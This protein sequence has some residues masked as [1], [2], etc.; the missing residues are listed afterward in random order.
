MKIISLIS[1]VLFFLACEAPYKENISWYKRCDNPLLDS[2]PDTKFDLIFKKE[3]NRMVFHNQ[4]FH[5]QFFSDNDKL[6][7]NQD[8]NYIL[9]PK[10]GNLNSNEGFNYSVFLSFDKGI[11]SDMYYV[12]S[13]KQG[14]VL[15][16][17]ATFPC[18]IYQKNRK[19]D[20]FKELN[21]KLAEF[22]RK[23]RYKLFSGTSQDRRTSQDVLE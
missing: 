3:E 17:N 7:E 6:Y 21:F 11:D 19:H 10:V 1:L 5:L 15:I 23:H 22:I 2:L 16:R 14:L 12:I 4:D 9:I 20:N 18:Y 13:D 8:S